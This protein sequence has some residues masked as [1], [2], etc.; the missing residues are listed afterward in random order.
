MV[1]AL[2]AVLTVALLVVFAAVSP[3]ALPGT[4]SPFLVRTHAAMAQP[5]SVLVI[6]LEPA[7]TVAALYPTVAD[8]SQ[9]LPVDVVVKSPA[10]SA[11]MMARALA[12]LDE[13]APLA[14][15]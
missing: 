8:V 5:S 12:L 1:A 2:A 4:D 7:R 9:I 14:A 11:A 6:D 13:R 10:P 15:P 3:P